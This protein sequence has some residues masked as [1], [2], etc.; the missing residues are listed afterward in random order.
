M[1]EDFSLL[2]EVFREK[3]S[4]YN[5]SLKKIHQRPQ[6]ELLRLAC[7]PSVRFWLYV[8][9]SELTGKDFLNSEGDKIHFSPSYIKTISAMEAS[10]DEFLVHRDD[11]WI[12]APFKSYKSTQSDIIFEPQETAKDIQETFDT[13]LQLIQQWDTEVFDEMIQLCPE[14]QFIKDANYPERI[15]S[16]S[17]NISPGAL[18]ISVKQNESILSPFFIADSLIHEYRHQKL[19]ILESLYP[20]SLKNE[21]LVSSPWR[22]DPRPPSGLFHAIFVFLKLLEFWKFIDWKF[23]NEKNINSKQEKR[24]ITN[25]LQCG[26]EVL[27]T[28][29]LTPLGE[30]FLNFFEKEIERLNTH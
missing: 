15:V 18:Y 21:P 20:I 17:D 26:I 7:R 8:L 22:D 6:T 9:N 19:Y 23:P 4:D 24:S 3:Y 29:A 13:A 10:N 27:K 5:D 14:I 30:E 11:Y 1:L 25:K 16:F 28:C 2:L 12:R